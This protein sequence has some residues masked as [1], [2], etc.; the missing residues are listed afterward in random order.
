MVLILVTMG[1]SSCKKSNDAPSPA[2]GGTAN[3]NLLKTWKVSEVLEGTI[4]VTSEFNQYRLTF[5]EADGNKTFT[6]VK[7]DGTTVTGTWSISDDETSIDLTEN[8]NTTRLS[9]LSISAST[10]KY[11]ADETGKTGAIQLAFTLMP[12]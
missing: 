4:D 7:R 11:S 1:L 9:G 5:A 8:G 6:L 3:A 12:A 10:L 2:A